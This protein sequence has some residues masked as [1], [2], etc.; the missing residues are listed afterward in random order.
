[1]PATQRERVYD[2]EAGSKPFDMIIDNTSHI[3]EHQII[4][5]N[6]TLGLVEYNVIEDIHSACKSW[7][8]NIGTGQKG[9]D[10]GGTADCMITN[11][12]KPTIYAKL[13]EWQKPLLTL[14]ELFKDVTHID[15][16]FKAAV[17]EKRWPSI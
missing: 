7:K 1:M 12:G 10:M 3:N 6:S 4:T 13:V 8:V 16:N 17:L 14:K 11:K 2:G 5:V 9:A 15:I